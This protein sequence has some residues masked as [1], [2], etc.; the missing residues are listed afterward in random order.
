MSITQF[1]QKNSQNFKKSKLFVIEFIPVDD[2][3]SLT[4]LD[5]E[6]N[7]TLLSEELE[8]EYPDEKRA[9]TEL[10]RKVDDLMKLKDRELNELREKN[11]AYEERITNLEREKVC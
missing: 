3:T 2:W 8:R 6:Q 5:G 7:G 10:A 9:I 4:S 11:Q 1:C